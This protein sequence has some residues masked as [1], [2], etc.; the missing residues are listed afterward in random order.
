MPTTNESKLL[1][2]CKFALFL[3]ATL[4]ELSAMRI[5][6]YEIGLTPINQGKCLGSMLRIT[7]ELEVMRKLLAAGMAGPE[8]C[9]SKQP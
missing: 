8:E 5:L 7:D 4:A 2:S 6:V 1:A 3:C 9:E